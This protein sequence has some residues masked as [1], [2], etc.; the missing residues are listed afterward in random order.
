MNYDD[1]SLA[2]SVLDPLAQELLGQET[3]ANSNII[4]TDIM[5]EESDEVVN[6]E[7]ESDSSNGCKVAVSDFM[8]LAVRRDNSIS[9]SN[10]NIHVNTNYF[11]W[12]GQGERILYSI[13]VRYITRFSWA[14]QGKLSIQEGFATWNS[15]DLHLNVLRSTFKLSVKLF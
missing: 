10:P 13:Q 15:A 4:K 2:P 8:R 3:R 12:H 5:R 7:F 9:W 6:I 1:L 11:L 14:R